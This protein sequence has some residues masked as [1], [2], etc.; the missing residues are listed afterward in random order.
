MCVS[1]LQRLGDY[2]WPGKDADDFQSFCLH[3]DRYFRP[4]T[5]AMEPDL[6]Q[7]EKVLEIMEDWYSPTR[8]ILPDD[9]LSFESFN[10]V[11][12]RLDYTSSPGYPYCR[13]K[14]TIGEWLGFD[15]FSLDPSQVNIL[16]LDVL[17]AIN[18]ESE[19][20]QRVF[21]KAEP[22]KKAKAE[23]G[24]W[25]L[26]MAFPLNHQVLW[27][28][29]F[30]YQ[31]DLEIKHASTIPSQQGITFH[32]G[33]WK[34]HLARWKQLGYDVGLDKS[35]WDWTYPFWLLKL[36]LEFR[37]RMGHGRQMDRWYELANSEWNKAF[38][39][40][41]RFITTEGYELEQQ[42]PG[43][44]KSG[45]VVTISSNSHGQAMLHI[46]VCDD[47][48]VSCDPYPACCGD[49]TL[50]RLDQ[51]SIDGYRKYGVVVKSASEGLEFMGH[52]MLDS[53]PHPL[54]LEKHFNRFLHISEDFLF[55]YLDAMA[56]LYVNT[57]YYQVWD[58]IACAFGK[59]VPSKWVLKRWYNHSD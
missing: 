25:R 49:D 34:S 9:W 46:L 36:D 27:H 26:I 15:G 8:W 47:E 35:A 52:E 22:H 29:L 21:I 2:I 19:L 54:Y 16:W 38:G 1:A 41:A 17:A 6:E 50:Q 58:D 45:S 13:H 55:D 44:M 42:V 48:G 11:L 33:A 30:D 32:G 3:A 7:R 5:M 23:E 40:G 56:R 39:K 12:K 4:M 28:M 57:P 59:P 14:Q 51:A 20:V 53:G 37:Y 24:R 18:G 43:I 10:K 31:N